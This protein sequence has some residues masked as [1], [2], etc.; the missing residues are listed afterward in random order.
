[1]KLY[2]Q[3]PPCLIID[4]EGVIKLCNEQFEHLIQETLKVRNIPK[5]FLK[6]IQCDSEAY[7]KFM[8][9]LRLRQGRQNDYEE[10][11]FEII[12]DKLVLKEANDPEPKKKEEDAP[13]ENVVE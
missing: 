8:N 3:A 5:D 13:S 11:E 10:P 9:I 6:F 4:K 1:M 12:L 7:E 2:S